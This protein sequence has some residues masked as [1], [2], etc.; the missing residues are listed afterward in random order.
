MVVVSV[1]GVGRG[2]GEGEYRG[3]WAGGNRSRCGGRCIFLLIR[4][5]PFFCMPPISLMLTPGVAE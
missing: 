1:G 5:V 3:W 2:A 4:R